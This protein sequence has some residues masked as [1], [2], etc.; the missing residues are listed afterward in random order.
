MVNN[1]ITITSPISLKNKDKITDIT[2]V[3]MDE[4]DTYLDI[5]K[6]IKKVIIMII[7]NRDIFLR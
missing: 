5:Y 3:I 4:S 1:E 7:N 2:P 6:V